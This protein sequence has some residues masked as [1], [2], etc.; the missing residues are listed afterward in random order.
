MT[1]IR[2][3]KRARPDNDFFQPVRLRRDIIAKF[4]ALAE[5]QDIMFYGNLMNHVLEQYANGELVEKG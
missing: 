1:E 4:K 5:K 3:K 2:K